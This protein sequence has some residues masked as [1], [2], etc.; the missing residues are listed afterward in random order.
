M[1]EPILVVGLNQRKLVE[2][3]FPKAERVPNPGRDQRYS[4]VEFQPGDEKFVAAT[5]GLNP[6]Q[7]EKLLSAQERADITEFYINASAEVLRLAPQLNTKQQLARWHDW[8]HV[9]QAMIGFQTLNPHTRPSH[10]QAF[11]EKVFAFEYEENPRLFV[12]EVLRV[13][14]IVPDK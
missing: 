10:Y 14:H 1:N 9:E 3:K 4:V 11:A 6:V 13:I 7:W 8:A 12:D 5:L 2:N